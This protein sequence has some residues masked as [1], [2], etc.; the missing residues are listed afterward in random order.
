RLLPW[1]PPRR[2]PPPRTP[3]LAPGRPQARC[4]DDGGGGASGRGWPG[5]SGDEGGRGPRGSTRMSRILVVEDEDIIRS[6]LARLLARTSH[7]VVE[8]R[9]VPEAMAAGAAD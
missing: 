3:G 7:D 6:E 2:R 9:S 4:G 1:P 5:R 8:A